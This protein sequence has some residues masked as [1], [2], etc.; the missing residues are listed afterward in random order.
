MSE[1]LP[2]GT[3]CSGSKERRAYVRS[4]G[5]LIKNVKGS[6][7]GSVSAKHGCHLCYRRT[8]TRPVTA[9][10]DEE[11]KESLSIDKKETINITQRASTNDHKHKQVPA[12][13]ISR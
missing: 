3:V 11:I 13:K 1:E 6:E 2:H 4:L 9:K 10:K 5:W 12:T 7:C 8:T